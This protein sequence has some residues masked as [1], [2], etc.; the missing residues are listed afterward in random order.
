MVWKRE[1]R[2]M[3]TIQV[4]IIGASPVSEAP[5]EL[6]AGESTIILIESERVRDITFKLSICD[7]V[8]TKIFDQFPESVSIDS[9]AEMKDVDRIY[10]Q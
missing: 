10:R 6:V 9:S 4:T 8:S 5:T 2:S 3:I 1:K 7:D